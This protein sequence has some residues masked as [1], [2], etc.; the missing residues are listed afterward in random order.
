MHKYKIC[1]NKIK[2]QCVYLVCSLLTSV[3]MFLST[4][5]GEKILAFWCI[6]STCQSARLPWVTPTDRALK[7]NWLLDRFVAKEIVSVASFILRRVLCSCSSWC[8][9]QQQSLSEWSMSESRMT[10]CVGVFE[11]P[12]V[13]NS[14]S[15]FLNQRHTRIFLCQ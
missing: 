11:V 6:K 2:K 1:K 3:R 15:E 5:A 10:W 7:P 13:W 12:G 9:S 4:H 14:C 8:N